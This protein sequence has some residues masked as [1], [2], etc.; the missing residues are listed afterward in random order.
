[1]TT[2]LLSLKVLW[3]EL[4]SAGGWPGL[5]HLGHSLNPAG[6]LMLAIGAEWL[7]KTQMGWLTGAS[8]FFYP[9]VSPCGLGFLG[10]VSWVPRRSIQSRQVPICQQF[11]KPLFTSRLLKSNQSKHVTCPSSES[12]R[13]GRPYTSVSAKK[14]GSLGATN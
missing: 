3:L 14:H 12:L 4:Q 2:I 7:L 6:S 13:D 10:H 9:M 11:I 8:C 5:D 1:M